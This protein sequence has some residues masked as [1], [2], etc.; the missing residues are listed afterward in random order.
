MHIERK[1]SLEI[2]AAPICKFA[3]S[4]SLSCTME[5]NVTPSCLLINSLG[6]EVFIIESSSQKECCVQS[7][8]II[9]PMT[10][11]VISMKNHI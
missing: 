4:R 1:A 8:F 11:Q 5:L 9:V 6:H 2:S 7:N 10:F 3:A